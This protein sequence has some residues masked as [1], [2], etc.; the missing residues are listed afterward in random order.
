MVFTYRL[1]TNILLWNTIA[2]LK[3]LKNLTPFRVRKTLAESRV[4]SKIDYASPVFHPLP[5]YQQK[6]LQRLLC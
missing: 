4:L 6:R 1:L 3:K 5:I 2:V